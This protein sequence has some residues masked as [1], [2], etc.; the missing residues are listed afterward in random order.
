MD[1]DAHFSPEGHAR[2]QPTLRKIAMRYAGIPGVIGLHGGFP[3]AD[4][5]PVMS[6]QFKLRDGTCVT[7]DDPAKMAAMQQYSVAPLGYEPLQAWATA[8][9]AEQHAPP[10]QHVT[11]ITPGSNATLEMLCSLLMSPGDA[12]LCEQFTYSHMVESMM[13]LRRY[14]AIPIAMDGA[15]LLPA[16]LEAALAAAHASAAQTG[17]SPP[18][19]LYTVPTGQNPTGSTVPLERK[20]QIYAICCKYDVVILEDDPYYYLQ[21]PLPSGEARGL[22]QLEGSYMRLDTE[23]RV[24]RLDSFAKF[25]A[26]GLRLGWAT[27][28]PRLIQKLVS[29]I[30]GSALGACSTTQVMVSE[31]LEAWGRPGLENHV[32]AMQHSYARRAG[33]VLKAAEQHLKGLATWVPPQGGMFLWLALGAGITDADE[34]LDLL[35]DARVVVV[36]G[37]ICHALGPRPPAAC[38]FVRISFAAAPEADLQTAMA[39]LGGVLR[40]FAACHSPA[41]ASPSAALGSGGSAVGATQTA[42]GS[43]RDAVAGAKQTAAAGPVT[44][45]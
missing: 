45:S 36:P 13:N 42:A 30:H 20:A 8:H 44:T 14:T 24:V 9:V 7:I 39:R 10:V 27:G 3:S 26:P 22:S 5:F 2:D 15:G 4:S 37:R 43:G 28:A 23:G 25:L 12:I 38:P 11:C 40:T 17:V 33:I 18:R 32:L 35:A 16:A 1:W 29:C 31:M 21:F 34:I 6:M 41:A 19:V